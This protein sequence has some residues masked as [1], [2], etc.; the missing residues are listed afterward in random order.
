MWYGKKKKGTSVH[1]TNGGGGSLENIIKHK[2]RGLLSKEQVGSQ[3]IQVKGRWGKE[4]SGGVKKVPDG[5]KRG[6]LHSKNANP[7]GGLVWEN[8]GGKE[9]GMGIVRGGHRGYAE[10]GEGRKTNNY[11]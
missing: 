6:S 4:K 10:R 7:T 11:F 5:D 1:K 8:S 3:A 2:E 9:V